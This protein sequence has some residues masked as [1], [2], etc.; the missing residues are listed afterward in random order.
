MWPFHRKYNLIESGVLRGAT[1]WHSHILPGVDDG[2]KTLDEALKVLDF[3]ENIGIKTLW[4]TPHVVED[5]PNTTEGLRQTFE[6]LKAAYQGGVTLHLSA[7][8]MLDALFEERLAT[9]DLLPIGPRG[10][11]LLVELSYLYPPLD[12]FEK[13]K[14]YQAKGYR[15]VMAHPER[16]PYLG[17]VDYKRMKEAG[18][19]FQLNLLSLTGFYGKA[20]KT[21]ALRLMEADFYELW[22]SDL[23]RLDVFSS[24]LQQ[25]CLDKTV[26]DRLAR[27]KNLEL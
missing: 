18:I 7:E 17:D 11:H 26:L 9:S 19:Q 14:R 15:L 13:L 3:Y 23:H 10:D 2:V 16:F 25:K 22:G 5:M 20:V 27:L 24:A 8:N 1:D 6:Q 21:K 12:L 4:L